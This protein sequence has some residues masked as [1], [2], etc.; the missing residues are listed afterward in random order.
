[1]K[2]QIQTALILGMI[3]LSTNSFGQTNETRPE[4]INE[5]KI[6]GN[7]YLD[8][9]LNVVSTNFH[10]G[11]SG[12]MLADSKKPVLGAQVGVSLQAGITQRLSLVSELYF[13][14]K[15]GKL[16]ANKLLSINKTTIRLY[17]IEAPVLARFNFGKL[18]VNAGPSIAYS[19]GGTMKIED[20]SKCLSFTNSGEGFKRWDAGVQMGAGYRFKIK[21]KPVVLDVRYSY[22]L[23]YI[24][25]HQEISNRYLNISLHF[26]KP[27]GTRPTGKK[28]NL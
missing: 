10:Y 8:L 9:L 12:N 23:S 28:K 17:T 24:S 18:Y 13:I 4:K 19:I 21:Q 1:M 6:Q 25:Y 5:N 3:L 11:K 20:V 27:C 2:K 26:S 22:G 7:T 15:G 16:E 14:M